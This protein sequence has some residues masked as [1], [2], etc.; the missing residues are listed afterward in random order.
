MKTSTSIIVRTRFEALHQWPE[1]PDE[2]GFLRHLHR[3]EFHV[4]L[5]LEVSHGDRE[6]EFILVKRAL[7]QELRT[8]LERKEFRHSCEW[9]AQYIL[10][11]ASDQYEPR[12]ASCEVSEDGENGALVEIDP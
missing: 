2:V 9:L 11:W 3:H 5:K 7:D 6:L 10:K 8:W 4:T 12:R 1:A